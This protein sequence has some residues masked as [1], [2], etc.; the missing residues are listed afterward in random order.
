MQITRN[1]Y[2]CIARRRAEIE[3]RKDLLSSGSLP[4]QLAMDSS[5]ERS[6][7]IMLNGSTHSKWG[8]ELLHMAS[9]LEH[10]TVIMDGAVTVTQ[11]QATEFYQDLVRR[12]ACVALPLFLL[13]ASMPHV[14]RACL[15]LCVC[16]CVSV[17]ADVCWGAG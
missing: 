9:E 13:P 17:S 4:P 7:A 12:E 11:E 14:D 2:R 1:E 16:M 5:V 10:C 8:Q 3:E 15:C 6:V